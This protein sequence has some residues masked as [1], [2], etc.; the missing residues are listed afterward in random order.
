MENKSRPVDE[1]VADAIDLER[2]RILTIMALGVLLT[3][4]LISRAAWLAGRGNKTPEL[5]FEELRIPGLRGSILNREG[6]V[7]AWSERCLRLVW[8]VPGNLAEA[9]RSRELLAE[10]EE[11]RNCLPHEEELPRHLGQEL[12]LWD[13]FT[14]SLNPEL[15]LLVESGELSLNGYFVRHHAISTNKIGEV[16]LD[17]I[18]GLEI[19]VSGLEKKHD[20]RLRG[21]VLRYSR[22][23]QSGKLTR[24]HSS[25]FSKSGN[26]QNIVVDSLTHERK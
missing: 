16:E 5:V 14:A 25:L 2:R 21:K 4:A 10:Q 12:L 9:E 1:C 6:E 7:L 20:Y 18:S 26:G 8:K 23:V 3:L 22:G 24:L 17:P 19:G 13:K 11:L 15:L